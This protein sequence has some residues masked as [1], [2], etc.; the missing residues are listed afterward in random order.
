MKK[1]IFIPLFCI[2]TNTLYAQVPGIDF[3]VN[4]DTAKNISSIEQTTLLFIDS[5]LNL[6]IEKITIQPFIPITEFTLR[7]DIPGRLLGKKFYYRFSLQNNTHAFL[8]Y[9]YYPGKLFRRIQLYKIDSNGN[10]QTLETKGLLSGFIPIVLPPDQT[11]TFLLKL[12]FF[13]TARNKMQSI[14]IAPNHLHSFQNKM[15]RIINEKKLV[16]FILSGMLLMMIL[17]TLLNYFITRKIEFLFNS[18]YSACMFFLIFLNSYL[19]GYPGWFRGF[20]LNYLDLLLLISGTILYLSFTRFFLD[21]KTLHPKLNKFL[22]QEAW[23]LGILMLLYT[24]L[25]IIF[26][27]YYYEIIFEYVLKILALAAGFVYIYLSMVQKNLLMNYLAVGTATQ[28]FFFIISLTLGLLNVTNDSIFTSAFFYFELGVI[29]SIIF[30]LLGLFYKNRRE[31][32][33]KIRE[34]EAMK[35][36]V[37][38]QSFENQLS[39]YKAQQEERNR[40]SEDMHD[41]LGA[42]MTAIRLYSEL[43]KSKAGENILPEIEK[44]SSSSDELINKMNAIIWSMS[45]HND[46]LGNM[47]S[48]IRSYTIDYL[49]NTGIKPLIIIPENLPEMVVN[50]IIRR[51]VF[52]VIKEALHNVIKHAAASEVKIILQKEKEGISLSI[53]D[54][55]KGIDFKNIRQFSNGLSNMKKRMKD[56]KIEFSIENNNGT[57]VK[58]YRKTR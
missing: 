6:P 11:T 42:G 23:A 4:T 27:Q 44:I 54:N 34:Q 48:Y 21:T 22:Y 47:V 7:N 41:D 40:I 5:N 9:Y 36:E 2:I 3:P 33:G 18:L 57:L 32:T 46:T 26:N 56:V 16:G 52:L 30:F 39:I 8:H 50:G 43:A 20:F 38:K 51:N 31:L 25:C 17:V 53:H 12:V 10:L 35:L 29:C 45:S 55:G 37:E 28:V 1:N 24:L 15:Y 58:L 49:E 13:T 19:G 14:L